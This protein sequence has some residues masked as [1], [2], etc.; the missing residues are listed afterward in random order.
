MG[1]SNTALEGTAVWRYE[2]TLLQGSTVTSLP[3]NPDRMLEAEMEDLT[4]GRICKRLTQNCI[5]QCTALILIQV[6][7]GTN[8]DTY[9]LSNAAVAS[10]DG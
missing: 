2:S 8:H 6:I 5:K 9:V 10:H 1:C 3:Y 7:L 4:A